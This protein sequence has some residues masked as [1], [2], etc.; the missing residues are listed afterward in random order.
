MKTTAADR[1]GGVVDVVVVVILIEFR[2]TLRRHRE[3]INYRLATVA[4]TTVSKRWKIT[5]NITS[6]WEGGREKG[7]KFD[8]KKRVTFCCAYAFVWVHAYTHQYT[9]IHARACSKGTRLIANPTVKI[10]HFDRFSI[11]GTLNALCTR[12]VCRVSRPRVFHCYRC[13]INTRARAR[14]CIVKLN[15][16]DRW[17]I[18]QYSGHKRALGRV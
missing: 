16:D 4:T 7:E 3:S 14:S 11:L 5:N 12:R 13:V 9:Y 1:V 6:K 17:F 2:A 15:G 8:A 18:I 10:I